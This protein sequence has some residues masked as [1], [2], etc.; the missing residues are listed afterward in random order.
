[1]PAVLSR[2]NVVDLLQL[3]QPSHLKG[4]QLCAR[5]QHRFR[6]CLD[7]SAL[8]VAVDIAV[9]DVYFAIRDST[10]RFWITSSR[11][12]QMHSACAMNPGDLYQIHRC[13]NRHGHDVLVQACYASHRTTRGRSK[14]SLPA[15]AGPARRSGS[16]S[17]ERNTW[18]CHCRC[19]PA[20]AINA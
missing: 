13:R 1:M 4:K 18:S 14:Q 12:G 20:I 7:P 8:P 9:M 2:L 6:P 10:W 5:I 15:A 3:S 17:P 19:A 16:A 11:V